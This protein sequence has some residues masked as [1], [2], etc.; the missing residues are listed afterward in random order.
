MTA[1]EHGTSGQTAFCLALCCALWGAGCEGEE[2]AYC[3]EEIRA[4]EPTDT[5][6]YENVPLAEH[7]AGLLGERDVDL[8]WLGGEE[9]VDWTHLESVSAI[10]EFFLVEGDNT[11]CIDDALATLGLP[12]FE[13]LATKYS[14][15]DID[16]KS[17]LTNGKWVYSFTLKPSEQSES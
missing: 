1:C 13:E 7:A 2:E 12:A 9:Y 17:E 11:Y 4:P 16:C 10:R 5:V 3:A 14:V 6:G 15:E 8:T